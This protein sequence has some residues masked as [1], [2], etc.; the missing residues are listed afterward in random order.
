[1][2][3][4]RHFLKSAAGT[5]LLLSL[6]SS[7]P[8]FLLRAAAASPKAADPDRVLVVVQLSGGNDGLNTV[9][10][11]ADDAYARSRPTLRLPT[12]GLHKLSSEL[13]LHPNME[14]MARLSAEGQLAIIQGVGSPGLS[15]DHDRALRFWQTA[16]PEALETG[17]LGRPG[18]S[19]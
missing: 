15:R 11:F 17:W 2:R 3:P 12:A 6:A 7:V 1:M 10:P 18:T 9:V 16:G 19:S 5:P 14:A 13:G 8:G 4:R